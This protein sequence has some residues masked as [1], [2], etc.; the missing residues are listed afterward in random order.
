MALFPKSILLVLLLR[1]GYG[2]AHARSSARAS[3]IPHFSNPSKNRLLSCIATRTVLSDCPLFRIRG[4]AIASTPA[5]AKN[6][7]KASS[8]AS[9]RKKTNANNIKDKRQR[10]NENSIFQL[11]PVPSHTIRVQAMLS[12]RVVRIKSLGRVIL[13]IFAT[14]F[15]KQCV[16]TAGIPRRQAIWTQ[17]QNANIIEDLSMVPP[18]DYQPTAL[19]TFLAT[20][21]AKAANDLLPPSAMPNSRPLLGTILATAAFILLTVLLPHWIL[22]VQVWLDYRRQNLYEASSSSSSYKRQLPGP[23]AILIQTSSD[24]AGSSSDTTSSPDVNNK[25]KRV[26]CKLHSTSLR[27]QTEESLPSFY[28]EH[29]YRRYYLDPKTLQVFDGG[30]NL[31]VSISTLV[32]QAQST[33]HHNKFVGLLNKPSQL[34]QAQD[35]WY[36]YNHQ[37]TVPIPTIFQ[38]VWE[39]LKSPL[40]VVQLIGKSMAVLEEGKTAFLSFGQTVFQHYHNARRSI[41]ASRTLQQ[42]VTGLAEE[43]AK[44][45]IWIYRNSYWKRMVASDLLPGDLF[46]LTT[47]SPT[48]S[49]VIPVDALVLD[50]LCVTMEA[51]LTGESVPQTK[52]PID[53]TTIEWNQ[54][55]DMT[56]THRN[57]VLFAGTTLLHCAPPENHAVRHKNGLPKGIVCLA[58]RTGSYSSKGKLIAVLTSSRTQAG[59]ATISNPQFD[60]DA[61][62]LITAMS[63]VTVLACASLFLKPSSSTMN[64]LPTKRISGF[65][66]TI[67]CTRI[68]SACIPSDLPLALSAVVQSC[69]N[70]LRD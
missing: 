19:D 3:T 29:E 69:K 64:T 32:Q 68:A 15:F 67:Q 28:F 12:D 51:V 53:S 9:T 52:M 56:G 65:R 7:S 8:A 42:D 62:R 43:F 61:L 34:M 27:A 35:R 40:V 31:Q 20:Q 55:L 63:F 54:T 10:R 39:R 46:L 23:T 26:L 21:V 4:G 70:C 1:I 24:G 11:T 41:L 45:P 38:A 60:R 58:L 6:S 30:P 13:S 17:L 5:T 25:Q 66:R 33:R 18:D 37:T 16:H 50:G 47:P 48:E 22:S 14:T 57:A 44:T 2:R 59:A 36:A 49:K